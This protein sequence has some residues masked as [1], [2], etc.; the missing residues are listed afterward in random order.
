MVLPPPLRT[1]LRKARETAC[2]ESSGHW[3]GSIADDLS[4]FQCD[5]DEQQPD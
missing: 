5:H 3:L 2:S 4:R 1:P